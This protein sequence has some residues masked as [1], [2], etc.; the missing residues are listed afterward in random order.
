MEPYVS[1]L[2][3]SITPYTPGEQPKEGAFIK[4]NTNENPFSPSPDAMAAMHE[5]VNA[6]LRL[7]PDPECA[8]LRETIAELHGLSPENVFVGNGSDEVLAMAF[9]AFFDPDRPILFPDITYSFYPVYANL[10]GLQTEQ[11]RLADDFTVCVEDYLRPSGGVVLANPNAPTSIALPAREVHRIGRAQRECGSTL[12]VD[13]AYVAF[14]AQT[15]A[16]YIAADENLLVV[17]TLSKSHSLAG[18][19]VGYAL[20]QPHLIRAMEN[21]KNSFNSYTLDAIA[22]AG[23]VA[24]MRDVRYTEKACRTIMETRARTAEKL[25]SFGFRVLP[26]SANFLFIS[27]P[28]WDGKALHMNLR[29]RG[30]LVRHFSAPRTRQYLRVSIGSAEEMLKFL[31][32]VEEILQLEPIPPNTE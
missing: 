19:R 26:S 32:A 15:M 3:Q 7:Y 23:A 24:A 30:I 27:H 29:M 14:G 6:R 28:K 21:I 16:T 4:L 31:S 18:L 5:A 1:R 13:E 8:C 17:R 12:V 20:G 11:I 9:Q 25:V 10:Y 22:I 2:A